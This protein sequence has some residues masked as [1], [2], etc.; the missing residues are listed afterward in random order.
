[1]GAYKDLGLIETEVVN[2]KE[3]QKEIRDE[4]ASTHGRVTGALGICVFRFWAE[5]AGMRKRC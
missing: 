4:I 1:M 2:L 3:F 5:P